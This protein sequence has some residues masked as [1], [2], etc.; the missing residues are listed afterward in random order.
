LFDLLI[1]IIKTPASL[2]REQS[3]EKQ[4]KIKNNC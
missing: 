2:Q 1:A 4:N 3:N